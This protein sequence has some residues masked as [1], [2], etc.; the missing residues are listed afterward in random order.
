VV[1]LEYLRWLKNNFFFL[2]G[3]ERL[4][5]YSLVMKRNIYVKN[6]VDL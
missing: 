1:S 6:T 5:K 2:S 4:R 3:K